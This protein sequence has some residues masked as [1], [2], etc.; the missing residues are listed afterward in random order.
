MT[1]LLSG[2]LVP[3]ALAVCRTE[4]LPH[5]E[6]ATVIRAL[7]SAADTEVRARIACIP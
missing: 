3:G 2:V 1:A 7:L 4:P 6:M 5:D